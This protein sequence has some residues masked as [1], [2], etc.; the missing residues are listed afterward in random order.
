MAE[1]AFESFSP[2]FN[3]SFHLDKSWLA[4]VN[5][6][7]G[8]RSGGANDASGVALAASLG[9]DNARLYDSDTVWS[10]EAGTKA[11]LMGGRM[12]LEAAVYYNDWSGIQLMPTDTVTGI[13][14]V[15]N[16][17]HAH[18][19]GIELS[20]SYNPLPGLTL[21]ASGNVNDSVLD[22]IDP[23]LTAV[24]YYTAGDRLDFIPK[25]QFNSSATY[26]W[27]LSG[28]GNLS[29][30]LYGAFGY[31]S[32]QYRTTTDGTFEGD[33]IITVNLR[34]GVDGKNWGA[35]IYADNLFNEMGR[36]NSFVDQT[37]TRLQPRV[38][39]LGLRANFN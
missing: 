8:F 28:S 22:K 19:K 21:Q 31:S 20:A 13:S 10:Y 30:S 24:L 26:K 18:T 6:A 27:A 29:G 4:Y 32:P 36:V 14:F 34:A 2:R 23:A 3:I 25:Y 12:A 11:E 38:I 35:Y 39:G 5:V 33:E 1:G 7:K 17:G 15:T 16:G 37:G 9:L